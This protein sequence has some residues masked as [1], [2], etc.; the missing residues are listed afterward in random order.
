M[1]NTSQLDSAF[2]DVLRSMAQRIDFAPAKY[3]LQQQALPVSIGWDSTIVRVV[4]EAKTRPRYQQLYD[5]LVSSFVDHT[6]VG[7]K[8]VLYYGFGN[9]PKADKV[10][11]TAAVKAAVDKLDIPPSAFGS[12]YPLAVHDQSILRELENTSTT[13]THIFERDNRVFFL[14]SSVRSFNE[15]VSIDRSVFEQSDKERLEDYSEIIGVRAIRRQ[16]FDYIVYDIDR[17][18]VELRIDCPDGMP[19]VHKQSAIQRVIAAFNALG[20]FA[21]GWSPFGTTPFNFHTLM[22][23]LYKNTG[24]GSAFQLGF[25]ASSATTA[26]NNGARLLRRKNS[27]LRKDDFHLGGAQKVKD[28]SVYTIGVEW[29]SD[30]GFNNPTII[31]PG[32]AKMIYK[33]PYMFSELYIR[34]CVTV[35]QYELLTQKI[36]KYSS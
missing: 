36:N 17:E 24:E 11:Y 16:C 9:L 15:R 3:L 29:K 10:N 8:A 26:S 35:S 28:I 34:G 4:A 18:L 32:S 30:M 25:T 33:P 5:Q 12:A 22:D 13:L 7:E 2:M 20:L 19:S 23:N 1:L 14:Y 27:D 6:L 31:V 21:S